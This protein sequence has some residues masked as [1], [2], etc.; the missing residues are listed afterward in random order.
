[1]QQTKKIVTS[2]LHV[3]MNE[4]SAKSF[5]KKTTKIVFPKKI[6]QNSNLLFPQI[7]RLV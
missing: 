7:G 2:T 3:V 4:W 5:K 6:Q 1:M